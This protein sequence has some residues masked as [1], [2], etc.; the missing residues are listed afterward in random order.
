M[1]KA[2]C[3]CCRAA[4]DGKVGGHQTQVYGLVFGIILKPVGIRVTFI[5][6]FVGDDQLA[7]GIIQRFDQID[8]VFNAFALNNAGGL[9]NQDIIR[10]ESHGSAEIEASFR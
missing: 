3:R 10:I 6:G 9:Q 7:A 1:K 8:G 5:A 2:D 4:R